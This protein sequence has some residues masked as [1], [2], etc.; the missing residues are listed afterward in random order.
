MDISRCEA[1]FP[2]PIHL[3]IKSKLTPFGD[4]SSAILCPS[5]KNRR[6]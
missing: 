3:E 6:D 2:Q 1:E 5:N 4:I